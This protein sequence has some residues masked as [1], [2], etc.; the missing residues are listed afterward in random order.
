MT[1]GAVHRSQTF[2][3]NFELE[4]RSHSRLS[5]ND[6]VFEGVG[7][8]AQL[9]SSFAYILAR[10][11]SSSGTHFDTLSLENGRF[12]KSNASEKLALN[13][14]LN[15]ELRLESEDSRSKVKTLIH[16]RRPHEHR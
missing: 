14:A 2:K 5:Q 7:V 1:F 11:L 3:A 4:S 10:V 9:K 13:L 16:S 6:P 12:F 8:F 15:S